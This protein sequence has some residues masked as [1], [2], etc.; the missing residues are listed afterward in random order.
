MDLP[1]VKYG[2]SSD[3]VIFL[4]ERLIRLGYLAG[5]AD[6]VYGSQTLD[7]VHAF[8]R[9]ASLPRRSTVNE[10]MWFALSKIAIA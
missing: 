2:E 1:E 3:Y 5:K 6:R 9:S 7:A 4:Q 8:Q 10:A